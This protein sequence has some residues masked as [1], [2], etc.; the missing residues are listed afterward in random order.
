M[1]NIHPN[2]KRTGRLSRLAGDSLVVLIDSLARPVHMTVADLNGDGQDDYVISGFGYLEGDLSWYESASG[3]RGYRRHV[4]RPLPGALKTVVNDFNGDQHLDIL[5]LMAQ[6]DE[7]FFLYEGDG[8]GNFRE[9]R[10]L[11]FSPSW[12][13]SYFELADMNGDGYEDIIYANGDNGDY[14]RPVLKPYHG[15]RVFLRE[16]ESIEFTEASFTPVNGPFKA[17]VEDYNMDG[18][19]DIACI[20]YFP[21]YERTPEE[22]FLI[23]VNDGS[24]SIGFKGKSLP[25]SLSGKWLTTDRADY[26]GDGDTDILLGNGP[27]MS[28]YVPDSLKMNW[29]NEPV[30]LLLLENKHH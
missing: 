25:V 7:G 29:E 24:E 3:E 20:S 23:L 6:G 21:D 12:G 8:M 28:L 19:P 22:S 27:I 9:K 15:I 4:L 1:G 5:A 2:D 16:G 26:D 14:S 10:I 13:S 11:S 18:Y 30:T 17:M